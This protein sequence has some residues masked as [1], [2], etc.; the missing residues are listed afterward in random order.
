MITSVHG[1]TLRRSPAI[2][3][4]GLPI[5]NGVIGAMVW[6]NGHPLKLTLDHVDLWDERMDHRFYQTP[7]YTYSNLRRLI[8]EQKYEEALEIFGKRGEKENALTP[9]KISI[10]RAELGV[11]GA[12]AF[13]GGLDLDRA[14]VEGTIQAGNKQYPLC[15]FVH[16][17]RNLVCL[18]IEKAPA[19]TELCLVPMAEA[20]P[21]FARLNYPDCHRHENGRM[22]LLS[23]QIPEGLCY[24]VAWSVRGPDFFLAVELARTID[25]AEAGATATWAAGV[26][27]GFDRLC[28][29][30]VKSWKTFW[31]ASAVV[32]PEP[33]MEFYWYYGIY[34]L[35]SSTRRGHLPPGLQGVWPMDGVLPPWRGDYH[36]DM[37]VQETFWPAGVTGHLDLLDC[38]CDYMRSSMESIR[39]YTRKLFG[40][41]GT[42]WPCNAYGKAIGM[43]GSN[44]YALCFSWSHTGWLGWM[45]WQRWRY[46]MDV[47]WLRETGYPVVA[48]IFRFFQANLVAEADGYLHVP[49]SSSPEY[50]GH[51]A[52]K[53]FCKDPNIDL[54]LIRK[55]CYWLMEM[56]TALG[57]HALTDSART[58]R[59]RLAPYALSEQQALCLWPGK[60]L[61]E[62]HRH[63]SQLMAIHP[64]MDLTLDGDEQTRIII[65]ASIRQY[66]SLGQTQWAGHT[67]AQLISM[68]AVLGKA[69]WA[70]DSLR[71]FVEH[72]TMPNGLHV[73][74]DWRFSGVCDAFQRPLTEAPFC[75]E[76]S[77]AVTA[78]ISDMLVQG[79]NN[80]IRV[81]P[82]VPDQWQDVVF[83]DLHTE[84]AFRV[85]GIRSNGQTVWVC[86]TAG[87]ARTL[88]MKN[89]FG[90]QPVR[91]TGARA[92]REG[93]MF[94][95]DLK[96]GQRVVFH[97][98]GQAPTLPSMIRAVRRSKATL[99][100]VN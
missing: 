52:A 54:A 18:R 9:T 82:A 67:Y 2:W 59:A 32:L 7:D 19:G 35:A 100:G 49:L 97:I 95:A 14:M 65:E 80:V 1:F 21:E 39:A 46:S 88:R 47:Q 45:V 56:E 89:P 17:E 22:R 38:W 33:D 28:R 78:G 71:Q 27:R 76:A 99:L 51:D 75:L 42:F 77:C 86:V 3:Q 12:Q 90:D 87:V 15:G 25:E 23:Q 41:E 40:T 13:I 53:A 58:V 10:G 60:L 69:A 34:L 16:R 11:K 73:V 72:W 26:K 4:N 5:G 94:L 55:C 66:L 50:Q 91:I 44:W 64:A 92:R 57:M 20:I 62:S 6:G 29:E 84:G 30:H 79:W 98:K 61:D 74:G 37:D 24:A 93:D 43:P 85:S 83:R 63:P 81:F 36:T 68:A 31:S 8:A 70:Y 48:D 96:P